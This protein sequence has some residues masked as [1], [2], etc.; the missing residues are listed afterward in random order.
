MFPLYFSQN[1]PV[2]SLQPFSYPPSQPTIVSPYFLQSF[3]C[4]RDR[5][6]LPLNLMINMLSH[7]VTHD[8]KPPRSPPPCP[9]APPN[10]LTKR[11]PAAEVAANTPSTIIPGSRPTN[12]VRIEESLGPLLVNMEMPTPSAR[13]VSERPR[14]SSSEPAVTQRKAWSIWLSTVVQSRPTITQ[15]RLKTQQP[16]TRPPIPTVNERVPPGEFPIPKIHRAPPKRRVSFSETTDIITYHVPPENNLRPVGGRD[17]WRI[18]TEKA[19]VE[20][21]ETTRSRLDKLDAAEHA[22]WEASR[23]ASNER[24]RNHRRRMRQA[25]APKEEVEES[26][27]ETSPLEELPGTAAMANP[28]TG[29]VARATEDSEDLAAQPRPTMRLMEVASRSH[30][31]ERRLLQRG[32]VAEQALE[33]AGEPG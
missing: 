16:Q 17:V 33:S 2:S 23:L 20:F 25:S 31:R 19:R 12:Y 8:P 21:R 5:H 11:G 29:S 30:R 14:R 28:N 24:S 1:S 9:P 6:L 3:L 18:R 15:P 26:E 10:T 7:P 27:E 13:V 4:F 22:H 32:R